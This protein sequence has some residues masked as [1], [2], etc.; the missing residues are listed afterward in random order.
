MSRPLCSLYLCYYPIT[1]PLVQTQ[2]VAYLAGLAAHGHQIHLLSFETE[3]LTAAQKRRIRAD[4]RARGIRWHHL[5][6]HKRPSLPATFYDVLCGVWK[7]SRLIR[8]HKIE[9]V[10]ARS[11]VPAAMG[12]MLKKLMGVSLIFDI[13]GLM[14]E[15]YVDA[16]NW[17][18]DGL[19]FR[20]TKAMERRCIVD[21]DGLVVLTHRVK[22][23][24]F[25][26]ASEFG[27]TPPA[28][29]RVIPCCADLTQIEAQHPQRAALRQRLGLE[30]K[31]VLIY[32]GKVG[33]WYM[34]GEMVEFFAAARA[35]IPALHFLVL[36]QSDPQL[37]V[38]EFER[39]GIDERHYTLTQAPP[40]QVGG[41]LWAADFALSFRAAASSVA[42]SP[43]KIGEYLAAGLPLLCNTG[44][45]DIDTL[46]ESH[47]IGVAI[48]EFCAAEYDR[49]SAAIAPLVG[50]E[51]VRE[52]CREAARASASLQQVGIPLYCALYQEVGQRR[53]NVGS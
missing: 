38:D 12:L 18:P 45:G 22:E 30:G 2:V 25:G 5:K 36:S 6:Y 13:R 26:A 44:V 9:V 35:H 31:T 53:A 33:G 11:H 4:L 19:P 14:A 40:A 52:R 43:T 24:L 7:A 34:Q 39:C 1:E 27:G 41:Y 51:T 49:A 48:E 29:L 8:R 15:E 16:G 32:V 46:V 17:T 50:D 21:A 28:P 23:L 20:L 10:H 42:A 3:P 37:M 47:K